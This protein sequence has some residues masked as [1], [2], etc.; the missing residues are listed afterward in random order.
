MAW[1]FSRDGGLPFSR[2]FARV[3]KR[4]DVP[5]NSIILTTGVVVI[6]GCI[7]LGSSSAFNAIVSASVVA[8]GVTYATPPLIN[9]LRGRKMLPPHRSF[10]LP[11]P[12][13]WI[14]NIVGI[15]YTI[16]TTVLFVFPPE[17]PVTGSSMN[18]C[19]V[20]FAI[21]VLIS[22]FQW[23]VDGR[24]NYTG[25]RVDI[26]EQILTAVDSP[27]DLLGQHDGTNRYDE[28]SK[29]VLEEP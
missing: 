23:I 12:L 19:V 11:E 13:G 6:I 9:V 15:L 20:A 16:L 5:L 10:K 27:A 29:K 21:V 26:D 3:D 28:P 24:K 22:L 14:V 1:A 17:L 2:F 18:Y 4:L 25:P 7:F 8:L